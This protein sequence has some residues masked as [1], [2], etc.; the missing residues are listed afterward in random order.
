MCIMSY[1]SLNGIEKG[2]IT[3]HVNLSSYVNT[4]WD[5]ARAM[6]T[7]TSSVWNP[8]Q[9]NAHTDYPASLTHIAKAGSRA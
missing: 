1:I 5:I 4:G 2:G 7:S 6:R 3:C 9:R 8:H